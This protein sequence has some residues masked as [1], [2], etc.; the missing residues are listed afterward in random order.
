MIKIARSP[1]AA[2]LLALSALTAPQAL[3]QQPVDGMVVVDTDGRLMRDV[4][5]AGA[6]RIV[7]DTEGRRLLLDTW[8]QV[9]GFEIPAWQYRQQNGGQRPR[10]RDRIESAFMSA[11]VSPR[12]RPP[13][14]SSAATSTR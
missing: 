9:I 8:D 4:P 6:V 12:L 3:A 14:A 1:Y 7:I 13:T 5:E 10:M 2:A 11:T